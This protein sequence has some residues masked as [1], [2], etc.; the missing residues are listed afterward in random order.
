MRGN[1]R[2]LIADLILG[3]AAG[4]A[5][6]WA[7]DKATTFLYELQPEETREREDKARGGK[8]A[9]EIAAEKGAKIAGRRL[10]DDE[11]K[12]IGSAIHW[13]VG[14]SSGA[15]YGLLRNRSRHVG[16]GSGLAYGLAMY[17][18]IDEGLLSATKLSPPPDAFPWQTHARGLAGHLILG[19]LLD[20]TF[21][22]ADLM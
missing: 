6:T 15:V 2:P 18:A 9:Y 12:K 4:A 3:A 5:A 11:R 17:L 20:G 7:M 22:L 1:G 21:D 16:F 10:D 14:V 19:L 8:T 13:T